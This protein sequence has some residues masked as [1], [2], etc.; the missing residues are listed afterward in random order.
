MKINFYCEYHEA[1]EH[2]PYPIGK[3][4]PEWYKSLQPFFDRTRNNR[5]V[6]VCV[7]FLDVLSSGYCIPLP[8]DLK[9][10]RTDDGN[11]Q[12]DF[13][14][15]SNQFGE[16][17]G[18]SKF[19]LD[20]GFDIHSANQYKGM[21]VPDNHFHVACK[22]I[23]PWIVTTPPGYSCLFTPPM[24]RERKYFEII[25]GIVDTDKYKGNQNF[26]CWL[27][28]WDNT[29][30]P[31]KELLIPAGTPI[32]HVFPF[33]RDNWKMKIDKRPPNYNK[34]FWKISFFSNWAHNY[35]NKNWTKKDYK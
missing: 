27:K 26:P 29:K 1:L 16:T 2:K 12:Y 23:L 18:G 10:N 15:I 20:L 4:M 9:L 13:G 17:H 24:N 28:H 7:P 32:A 21:P 8:V 31:F 14:M 3:V 19:D 33:K 34:D 6:K 5:T 11:L 25:S 30:G 35:R 22:F